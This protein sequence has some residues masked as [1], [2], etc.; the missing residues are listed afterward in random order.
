MGTK[1]TKIYMTKKAILKYIY[2]ISAL[3]REAEMEI[4]ASSRQALAT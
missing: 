2:I 1:Y 3:R 4:L